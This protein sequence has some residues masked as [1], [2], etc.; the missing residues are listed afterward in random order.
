MTFLTQLLYFFSFLRRG[1]KSSLII[2]LYKIFNKKYLVFISLI[3]APIT[4]IKFILKRKNT[5]LK[6]E[7]SLSDALRKMGPIFIKFGQSL[8][9]RPDLL[10]E[11]FTNS[12]IDLQDKLDPFEIS[13]VNEILSRSLGQA[14]EKI[15]EFFEEEPV[16]AASIAQVHKA[17][18]FGGEQVA[19]KILRPNIKQIYNR[20]IQILYSV[21]N[22][23][24]K[25]SQKAKKL[26]LKEVIE[27]FEKSMNFELDLKNEAAACSQIYDNLKDDQGVLIPKI[28]WNFTSEKVFTLEWID[29]ISIYNEKQIQDLPLNKEEITKNLALTFLNQAF[30]DG[31]FHAD[32]HPGNILITKDGKIA[33]VDFGIVGQLSNKDR[34][35]LAEV[36]YCLF[37]KD[38]TRVAEIHVE[39]GFLPK[40][41]NITDFALAARAATEPIIG[42]HTN[43]LSI[44]YLIE[45][46]IKM[47]YKFGMKTQP[48]LILL[49]KTILVV[50]G[51][52]RILSP[53]SNMWDLSRP[54][55]KEW[56]NKNI[57]FDAKII[58]FIK[59]AILKA[60]KKILEI[61]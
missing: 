29:G 1:A 10:G 61:N 42:K 13:Q 39:I 8:S 45:T 2:I 53:E 7:L 48:Q 28:Y 23:L 27:I 26:K 12:L 43:K 47:N 4:T 30:R 52:G 22:I 9:T 40:D 35:A 49:Q 37:Q 16:A 56:A 60:E 32:M 18:L 17:R 31:F 59:S 33:F 44:G 3:F 25:F 11:Y 50:E 54:W 38:Y 55:I 24:C 57:T 46:L 58:S 21:I 34:M 15:F 41:V 36:L 6:P 19:V 51:I 5:E 14:P 20:D